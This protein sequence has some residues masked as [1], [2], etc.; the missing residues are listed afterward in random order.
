MEIQ[1]DADKDTA[2]MAKHGVSLSAAAQVEW[3]RALYWEDTRKNYQERR[4]CELAPID[5]R[6]YYVV[7][8]DRDASRRIVSLRKANS[9]EVKAYVD[10]T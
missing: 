9:R 8:V 3:D 1:F 7:Y 6:L 4:M 10:K 5:Q 2:N